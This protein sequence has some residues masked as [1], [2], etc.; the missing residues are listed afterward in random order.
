MFALKCLVALNGPPTIGKLFQW[1]HSV[2]KRCAFWFECV[3]ALIFM[4]FSDLNWLLKQQRIFSILFKAMPQNRR[5][6]R[7]MA[8]RHTVLKEQSVTRSREAAGGCPGLKQRILWGLGLDSSSPLLV[9]HELMSLV[10]LW[11]AM[12][13]L[14]TCASQALLAGSEVLPSCFHLLISTSLQK[15]RGGNIR[16]FS[17]TPRAAAVLSP[18]EGKESYDYVD[19]SYLQ[20]DFRISCWSDIVLAFQWELATWRF[21]YIQVWDYL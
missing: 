4:L 11:S 1:I 10:P 16:V 18:R 13:A 17:P 7:L 12:F 20:Y 14:S 15:G 19:Q 3:L 5:V 2:K 8:F 6:S 9:L 21:S